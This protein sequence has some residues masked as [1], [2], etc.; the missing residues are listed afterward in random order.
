MK[1]YSSSFIII[2]LIISVVIGL[3]I[4]FPQYKNYKLAEKEFLTKKEELGSLEDYFSDLENTQKK[5]LERKDDLEKVKEGVPLQENAPLFLSLIKKT[6]SENG[7][8]LKN[9]EIQREKEK[10][11]KE[12]RLKKIRADI[13]LVG[14]YESFKNFISSLEK[15]ARMIEIEDIDFSPK[16][17]NEDNFDFHLKV[18][19]FFLSQ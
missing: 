18:S 12:S 1:I 14:S 4:T 11:E 6:S 10:L 2:L 7:L 17:E 5:L 13:S 3:F 16:G 9:M 8:I 15:N 19:A